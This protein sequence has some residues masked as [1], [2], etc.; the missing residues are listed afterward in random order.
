MYVRV[1]SW[2]PFTVDI[3]LNA[4]H[5]LARQL[6]QAGIGY[7][8]RAN[9]LIEVADAAFAQNLLDK[10]LRTDW[11]QR[12]DEFLAQAHPL[13]GELC[14][15]LTPRYYWSVSESEFATD[16]GFEN[17]AS[18]AK[19]YPQF[20]HHGIRS[21]SSADVFCFLGKRAGNLA[22]TGYATA[23]C[24]NS[25]ALAEPMLKNGLSAPQF[26]LASSPC[27]ALMA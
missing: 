17:A 25:S 23:I 12:L 13:S 9:C 22:S 2:F 26:L 6:T 3:C 11:S 20:L 24:R 8:Q 5:W 27:C 7:E 21:F 1:Q 15:P 19:F 16:V 14:K 10:Q 4:R 18:L